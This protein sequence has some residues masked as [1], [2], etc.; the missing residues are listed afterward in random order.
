MTRADR[1]T[2]YL[3]SAAGPDGCPVPQM[4]AEILAIADDRT[5]LSLGDVCRLTGRAPSTVKSWLRP[6]APPRVQ[7]TRPNPGFPQPAYQVAA[8]GL[9]DEE[10]IMVWIAEHPEQ[11]RLPD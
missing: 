9:W 2:E 1:I 5:L 7:N 10:V 11:V 3:S 6:P 8:G 4:A